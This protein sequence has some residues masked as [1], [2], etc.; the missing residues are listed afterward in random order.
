MCDFVFIHSVKHR[1]QISIQPKVKITLFKLESNP[2]KHICDMCISTMLHWWV[3]VNVNTVLEF[4]TL[5]QEEG[6]LRT[7]G[8]TVTDVD[9]GP[10]SPPTHRVQC[11]DNRAKPVQESPDGGDPKCPSVYIIVDKPKSK[12]QVQAQRERGI[13]TLGLGCL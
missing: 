1:I 2:S 3:T 4:K 8:M 10:P 9:Q 12:S 13:L 7:E 5:R 11:A 6:R